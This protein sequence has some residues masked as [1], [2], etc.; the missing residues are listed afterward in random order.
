M[1]RA[2]S[3][4]ARRPPA[5]L[6]KAPDTAVQL[7]RCRAVRVQKRAGAPFARSS[8]PASALGTYVGVVAAPRKHKASR[9][10]TQV[11]RPDSSRPP[12][13]VAYLVPRNTRHHQAASGYLQP[14]D[15]QSSAVH[16]H[17]YDICGMPPCTSLLG[18]C[19]VQMQR[20]PCSQSVHKRHML[21]CMYA[22]R[23]GH[24]QTRPRQGLS[25]H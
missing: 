10:H 8:L 17:T 18:L 7:A 11:V 24:H 1:P 21:I 3:Q 2:C 22:C 9:N 4:A 20:Q 13:I 14:A 16:T 12:V 23:L 5:C 15:P 19:H 25:G 6:P